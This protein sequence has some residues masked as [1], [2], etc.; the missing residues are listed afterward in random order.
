MSNYTKGKFVSPRSLRAKFTFLFTILNKKQVE[1]EGESEQ[2]RIFFE[3][4]ILSIKTL[5]SCKFK[6]LLGQRLQWAL[7]LW[8]KKWKI[9]GPNYPCNDSLPS[10]VQFV[11]LGDFNSRIFWVRKELVWG[12][13]EVRCHGV[14]HAGRSVSAQQTFWGWKEDLAQILFFRKC[15][16]KGKKRLVLVV[17]VSLYSLLNTN[18]YLCKADAC[19]GKISLG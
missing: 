14:R 5:E 12:T 8:A 2:I 17:E 13:L 4:F 7:F 6:C 9:L 11:L 1:K 16:Y 15:S 18:L 10:I 19:C 3:N